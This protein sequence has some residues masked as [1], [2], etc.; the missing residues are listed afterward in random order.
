M[1]LKKIQKYLVLSVS[2]VMLWSFVP[3]SVYAAGIPDKDSNVIKTES[4]EKINDSKSEN[5]KETLEKDTSKKDTES[6]KNDKN[7]KDTEEDKDG[8]GKTEEEI[9]EKKMEDGWNII[10]GKK[11][12]VLD[13]EI[14]DKTGWFMESD[15]IK[16]KNDENKY[17]LNDDHS[18]VTGWKQLD[19]EWYY[20]NDEGIL[21]YGW[22]DYNGGRYYT[23]DDG[24]MLKGWNEIKGEKY[25]FDYYGK[26][27]TGKNF[28][29]NNFYFFN[30][31]GELQKGIYINGN[32]MYYSDEDGVMVRDSWVTVRNNKYYV[33][34]DGTLAVGDL[35]LDGKIYN[36]SENGKLDGVSNKEEDLLYVEF[37]SVGDADCAFIKLPSGETALIDTGD[38]STTEKLLSFL[39]SQNLKTSLFK[40]ND[41]ASDSKSTEEI[42]NNE[43]N[44]DNEKQKAEEQNSS[45]ESEKSVN[46]P[47]KENAG[48]MEA[49]KNEESLADYINKSQKVNNDLDDGTDER[50][51]IDYVV[52]THPHSDHIGGMIDILKNYRVGQVFI[53]KNFKLVDYSTT[54]TGTSEKDISDKKIMEYDYKVYS[55]T[56]EALKNSNVKVT[57][58]VPNSYI[59]SEKILQFKNSNTDFVPMV[60]QGPYSKYAA[61][62]NNSAIVYLD[63]KDLQ[64]LFTADMEWNAEI[65][66]VNRKALQGKSVDVLKVPHHGNDSSSS[67]IFISYVKPEVGVVSRSKES[68]NKDIAQNINETFSVC[69][70]AKYETSDDNGISLYSTKD[71]WTIVSKSGTE[72]K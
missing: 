41:L 46:V 12:Y 48:P 14:I 1:I 50:G 61:Y 54:V 34:S 60:N 7:V 53:P 71:N 2:A 57:E 42:K 21:Q 18:V 68:I 6:N 59:D 37:L 51:V 44:Q 45:K 52:L 10:D 4:V 67:Y 63:Y 72:Q 5:T 13:N 15:V 25:Y 58:I 70:V 11:Y 33:K 27:I 26:M 49:Y 55:D 28:L 8:K 23:D 3:E 19:D 16:K 36:F 43:I 9:P 32:K 24:V 38:V 56:I 17:Y 47:S 66:F 64:A 65:D 30:S 22:I 31:K 29:D 62:N 20:F 69:G 39:K 35:Y 40:R